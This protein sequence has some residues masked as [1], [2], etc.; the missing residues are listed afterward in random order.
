MDNESLKELESKL[1]ILIKLIAK[2]TIQE[3]NQTESI[4]FLGSIGLDRQTIAEITG[5]SPNT[6]SVRLSEHKNK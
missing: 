6:V 5:A 2:N 3:K 4:V 1:D